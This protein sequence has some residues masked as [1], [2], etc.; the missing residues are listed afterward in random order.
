MN[1]NLCVS[2][3]GRNPLDCM[4]MISSCD[5]EI[6][7]HRMDYMDQIEQLH[8]IYDATSKPIIA[9]CRPSAFGGY[10][11]GHEEERTNYLI[12]ALSAG[13]S[14]VDIEMQA[15]ELLFDSVKSEALE[16][17]SRIILSKHYW[18]STPSESVLKK[19]VADIQQMKPD[20]IKIVTTAT[21]V[22][23]CLRVLHLYHPNTRPEIPLIAFAM[24]RIGKFTRV[25]S[26][27]L[28]APF[29]YVSHDSG[30]AAAAG[31]IPQSTM[32]LV[33]EVLG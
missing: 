18:N 14:Y 6:I 19:N 12:E 29:G 26:L 11:N 16:R 13:A 27:F 20:I 32:R 31:Q 1:E 10:F 8:E 33:L 30:K 7:E 23:D 4:D 22:E 17:G 21:S 25:C 2:I 15:T 3:N 24:G 9:T 5:A 28:G